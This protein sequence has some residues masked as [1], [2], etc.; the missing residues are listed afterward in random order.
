MMK[1]RLL[2]LLMFFSTVSIGQN[3]VGNYV[4]T[5]TVF[6]SDTTYT[7]TGT[8]PIGTSYW[9]ETNKTFSDVLGNNVIGQRY[10]EAFI[11]GQNNTGLTIAN[12]T[13][14]MYAGSIGN[15]GNIRIKPAVID[16]V[17]PAFYFLGVAT[18]DIPNDSVGSVTT[19]GKLREIQTDGA[20][21]GET[22]VNGDIIYP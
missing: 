11:D 18:E 10:K 19:R 13:P 2:I 17:T 3:V 6:Y 20:N 21:Y 1:N 7:P 5:R 15:S 8:E 4:K 12:G 14:V 16:S 22:W 9:D